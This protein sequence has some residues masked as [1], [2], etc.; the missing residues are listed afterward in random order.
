MIE[1]NKTATLRP[2]AMTAQLTKAI[3]TRSQQRGAALLR[4]LA[5]ASYANRQGLASPKLATLA[6]RTALELFR[7]ELRAAQLPQRSRSQAEV[8]RLGGELPQVEALLALIERP[9]LRPGTHQR[10]RQR[11]RLHEQLRQRFHLPLWLSLF[12]VELPEESDR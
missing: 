6:R 11:R 12:T 5:L 9:L 8:L 4:L 3:W 7:L 10:E 2:T 1:T